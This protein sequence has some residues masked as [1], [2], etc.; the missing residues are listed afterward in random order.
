MYDWLKPAA[1]T[2]T[3]PQQERTAGPSRERNRQPF[4][5]SDENYDLV[6][7]EAR[8]LNLSMSGALN[9]MIDELLQWRSGAR[10]FVE[11]RNQR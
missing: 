9:V 3:S 8:R 5:L 10:R 4:S 7:K 6:Q 2:A 1:M 11:R